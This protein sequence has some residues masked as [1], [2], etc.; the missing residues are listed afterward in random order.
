MCVMSECCLHVSPSCLRACGVHVLVGLCTSLPVSIVSA[1]SLSSVTCV[2]L[3]TYVC[4]PCLPPAAWLLLG[5]GPLLAA[6][7]DVRKCGPIPHFQCFSG[8]VTG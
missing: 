8:R 7:P 3:S 1:W 5:L 4:M 2:A 6:M